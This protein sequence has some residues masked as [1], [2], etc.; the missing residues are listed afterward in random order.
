MPGSRTLSELAVLVGGRVIGNGDL[1]VSGLNG[2]ELAGGDEITFITGKRMAHKLTET[3][4]AA[5]IVPLD[6]EAPV[7]PGIQVADPDFAAAV[8]HNHFLAGPFR[9][10]GIHSSAHVGAD[11]KISEE[12]SIGP[13][14]CI[15]DRVRIGKRVTI[16]P[17]VVIGDDSII[18][19]DTLLYANVTVAE[20]SVIGS[21]VI[22]HAGV[23]IG[24]DGFGY[25]TDQG[26]RHMKKPQVGNVRIDDDV[27]IGANT[28]VDRAAFGTTRI[29]S[30]VKIDN[31]VMVAH[32][33]DIGENSI[34]VAQAG[35]AGS[36][37]LGRNVVLG[38]KAGVAGHLDIGDR[39]MV[40]AMSG[41]HNSLAAG[42]VV[43]GAPAF[44]VKKWGRA[45]AAFGRLPEMVKEIRR[46]RR[47]IERLSG[48]PE[49][50]EQKKD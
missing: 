50:P 37:K 26:G 14:V 7:L 47:E 31:L 24:S 27:E 25:A 13:L 41:V 30:G 38:A 19:D 17:G 34:L 46:L 43:G 20:R 23:V 15:G 39:V 11:S 49:G 29:R 16:Y 2:I 45:T 1:R 18:G 4:A 42:S 6:L 22:I 28:C 32:N 8:I 33:V 9:A 3:R 21:R 44:E 35:I 12:I 36:T 48:L 5:C 40:A 10:R